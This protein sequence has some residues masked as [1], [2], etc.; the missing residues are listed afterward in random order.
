M[1]HN[2][3]SFSEATDSYPSIENCISFKILRS[4]ENYIFAMI[5]WESALVFYLH[6]SEFWKSLIFSQ[7]Y[8]LNYFEGMPEEFYSYLYRPSFVTI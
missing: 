7:K 8:L 3:W 4:H 6:E 1:V 2:N 5:M